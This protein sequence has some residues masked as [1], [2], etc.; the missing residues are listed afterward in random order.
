VLTHPAR[1]SA[2]QQAIAEIDRLPEVTAGTRL[3]R[4]EEDL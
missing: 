4:I 2:I 1:E 3:V